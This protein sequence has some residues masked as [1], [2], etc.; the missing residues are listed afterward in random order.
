MTPPLEVRDLSV[1]YGAGEVLSHVDLVLEPGTVTGLIGPNGAGKTTLLDA[2]MGFVPLATGTVRLGGSDL[3]SRPPHERA[4]LG[5]GRSFQFLELFDDL[6]A[7]ENLLIAAE[8]AGRR[9]PRADADDADEPAGALSPSA[10]KELALRRVLAADPGVVLLDEPG[11]GLDPAERQQLATELRRMAGE[12]RTV[13]VVDH[14]LDLVLDACDRIVVLDRGRIVFD[15]APA[16]ARTDPQVTALYLG[17][18]AEAAPTPAREPGP[19]AVRARGLSG[20][21]GETP[22]LHGID[23][24]VRLGEVVALLGPNGAGK[25]T[26]LLALSGA[27]PAVAGDV[28]V[29]GG[30]LDRAH[31]LARRGVAAVLQDH[32]LFLSLTGAEN[33]RLAARDRTAVDDV[34]ALL[35]G[36]G[37][38]LAR[39]AGSLSG[40]EQQL[41]A[42][43][44]ALARRPQ[45]LLVDELSIGL[46]PGAV[47]AV[48][49]ALGG[50]AA[51][52][53][54]AV[55][56]AE[57]H[58][59]HALR[60]ADRAYVLAAGRVVLEAS[61]SSLRTD[62]ARL[63]AA[64]LG[65]P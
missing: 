4:R 64:Y 46:A 65:R 48:F 51:S 41:L 30:A 1:R 43:A 58:V 18:A 40:G 10:R 38:L 52:T 14:D 32:K 34:T 22:V 50:Y 26:T 36:V 6:T 44:R 17:V 39:P 47:E 20:G 31:R 9:R 21:Y 25:T 42:V 60:L 56:V 33:L 53:G 12:N 35:P 13:L 54:A 61:A 63:A 3:S 5:L 28:E 23:L 49:R 11:A 7:R 24:D 8:S 45:L 37:D 29:L 16:Q 59:E 62:R 19:P 2:V 57:Q 27:L 55:V 15:G